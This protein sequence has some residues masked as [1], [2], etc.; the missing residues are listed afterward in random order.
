[1]RETMRNMIKAAIISASGVYLLGAAAIFAIHTALP[2]TLSLAVLR[3]AV[4]PLWVTTGIP[5]G[6]PIDA[7]CDDDECG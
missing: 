1:M 2:V 5:H 6:A 4:W 3:S 7:Q